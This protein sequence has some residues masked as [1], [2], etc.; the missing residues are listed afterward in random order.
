MKPS[1]SQWE[2]EEAES[3]LQSKYAGEGTAKDEDEQ[4]YLEKKRPY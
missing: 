4:E 2:K 1:E 3:K